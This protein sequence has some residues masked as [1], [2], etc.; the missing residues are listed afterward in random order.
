MM[1][2]APMLATVFLSLAAVVGLWAVTSAIAAQGAWE[3]L[4]RRFLIGLRVTMALF[5]GRA[6]LVLTG[7][8]AFRVVELLAAALIPLAVLMLTEGLLRRHAPRGVKWAVAGGAVLFALWAFAPGVAEELRWRGLL[9]YQL[10]A[11]VAC[12]WLV[13]RRDRASLSAAENRA[14]GRLGLSLVLLVPLVGMDFVAA[15]LGVPVQLSA[16]AVLFLCWLAIGLGRAEQGHGASLWG[17]ALVL[18]AAG[19]VTAVLALAW[20]MTLPG[21]ALAGAVVLAAMLALTVLNEARSLAAE[22]EGMSLLRHLAEG[23]DDPVVFL[24]RLQGHPMVEGALILEAGDLVDLDA[25]V[26]RGVFR[27]R[28]VI[29]R[30]DTGLEAEAADYAAHLFDRFEA[31]HVMMVSEVPLRLVALAMPS[32]AASSRAELEL[33]AVQRMAALMARAG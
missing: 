16:L 31:S 24:R 21:A 11:L 26:L 14:V 5:A 9:V 15:D 13:V 32:V 4:N 28:P 2:G 10:G 1:V 7:V 8:G 25:D 30:A 18:V 22:A 27:D 33:A 23:G 3:P 20:S 12:G 17:F 19:S 6:L 29:R